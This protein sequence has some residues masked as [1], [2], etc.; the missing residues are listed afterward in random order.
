ETVPREELERPPAEGE[1]SAAECL[2]HV[3]DAEP[4]WAH[5]MA[6][7]RERRRDATA[8]AFPEREEGRGPD[9]L[10]AALAE[11]RE[12]NLALLDGLA[13]V[14]LSRAIRHPRNGDVTLEHLINGW[15]AHD[16]QHTVQA[17]EA[18]MQPFIRRSG[19]A[20]RAFADHDVE[21]KTAA[22]Q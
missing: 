12:A 22:G 16:L 5:H 6:E 4:L 7:F 1:W 14:E 13:G 18:L 3:A 20:R 2:R 11:Q 21:A 19:F 15:A 10:L 9:E 8:F 17:E